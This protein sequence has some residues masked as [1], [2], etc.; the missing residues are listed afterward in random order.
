MSGV[1]AY[2]VVRSGTCPDPGAAGVAGAAVRLLDEGPLAA[3]VSAL[4]EEGLRVRRRD[5]RAH[6]DVLESAFAQTTIVPC[7]FGAVFESEDAVRAELLAADSERLLALLERLDGRAQLTLH[8]VHDEELVLREI[9][10]ADA[11]IARLRERTRRA[12]EEGYY[13]RIRLGELVAAAVEERV[14]EDARRIVGELAA[15]TE[16][17]VVEEHGQGYVL[18]GS[19]LVRRDGVDAVE[20]RLEALG[21][22]AAGRLRFELVG[23]LPPTAFVEPL[24][25][26]EPAWA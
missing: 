15:V 8:A 7:R 26:E 17:L 5:L 16:R 4:P 12:G 10:A 21:E 13:A 20:R 1:Y 6:L 2:G 25:A 19:L 14:R 24:E 23:P 18:A 11:E 9:V 3:L 22:E